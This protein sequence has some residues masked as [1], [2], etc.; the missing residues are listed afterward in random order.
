MIKEPASNKFV[1]FKSVRIG[2]KKASLGCLRFVE[3][4]AV[5]RKFVR[6][7]ENCYSNRLLRAYMAIY[8]GFSNR[9]TCITMSWIRH[10]EIRCAGQTER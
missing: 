8:P 3:G 4:L 2:R 5:F 9:D 1:N 6:C 10:L 7:A